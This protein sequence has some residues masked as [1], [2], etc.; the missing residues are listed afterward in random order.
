MSDDEFEEDDSDE[1]DDEQ[2]VDLRLVAQGSKARNDN[3][4]HKR[5]KIG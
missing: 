4:A 2:Q 3:G 5:Q 1:S